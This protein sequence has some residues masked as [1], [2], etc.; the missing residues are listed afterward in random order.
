MPAG[1]YASSVEWI[2]RLPFPSSGFVLCF[3]FLFLHTYE[4]LK[5]RS[6]G[7]ADDMV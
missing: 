1:T 7:R 2:S 5:K 4:F 6:W 3:S